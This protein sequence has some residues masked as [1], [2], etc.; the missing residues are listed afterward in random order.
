MEHIFFKLRSDSIEQILIFVLIKLFCPS[1]TFFFSYRRSCGP[2]AQDGFTAQLSAAPAMISIAVARV[3]PN[4]TRIR[5]CL[6]PPGSGVSLVVYPTPERHSAPLQFPA[7]PHRAIVVHG[8][9]REVTHSVETVESR[10]LK[11]K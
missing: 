9:T 7:V 8:Y 1:R 11:K 2:T 4:R 5:R 6:P 3:A 10:D